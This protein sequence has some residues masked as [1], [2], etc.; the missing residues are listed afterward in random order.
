MKLRLAIAA[1]LAALALASCS[2]DTSYRYEDETSEET[3]YYIEWLTGTFHGERGGY[4]EDITFN[5]YNSVTEVTGITDV[6]VYGQAEISAWSDYDDAESDLKVE[7]I[8]CYY[9]V[10]TVS[11]G[12]LV[13]YYKY[14]PM[15]GLITDTVI[16]CGGYTLDDGSIMLTSCYWYPL[17]LIYTRQ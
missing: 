10:E 11:G 13:Y 15:T 16:E 9:S 14:D 6:S 8:H 5:P 7:T 1:A 17:I 4:Y 2:K 3:Q 12:L